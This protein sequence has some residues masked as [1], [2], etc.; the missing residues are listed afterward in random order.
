MFPVLPELQDE[1]HK[2][3]VSVC[4]TRTQSREHLSNWAYEVSLD[5]VPSLKLALWLKISREYRTDS[6]MVLSDT[7][8][9]VVWDDRSGMR[10]QVWKI[11]G[12][13]IIALDITHEHLFALWWV[14]HK[15]Y[16]F[17][18]RS[19]LNPRKYVQQ[20]E[21]WRILWGR[22]CRNRSWVAH[23]HYPSRP[24]ESGTAWPIWPVT[25]TH[26]HLSVHF[27]ML[28]TVIGVPI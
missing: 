9:E 20:T 3:G 15:R 5:A 13:E 11:M 1:S 19:I 16:L 4:P 17:C 21:P 28:W 6:I 18:L 27:P 25:T 10:L 24:D 14:G 22:D 8:R 2:N 23:R 7:F 26:W 12:K